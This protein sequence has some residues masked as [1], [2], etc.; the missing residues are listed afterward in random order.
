MK[1]NYQTYYQILF[2][3]ATL[4]VASSAF[5]QKSNRRYSEADIL[6]EAAFMEADALFLRG[7]YTESI[8]KF[9]AFLL[10][11]HDVA[12]AH[13]LLGRAYDAQNEHQKSMLAI[14]KAID[15]DPTNKWF[16]VTQA[17][18]Y[19]KNGQA[20]KAADVMLQLIKVEPKSD[21]AYKK[22]AFYYLLAQMPDKAIDILNQG[23]K[24]VGCDIEFCQ[25]K[26][27]IYLAKGDSKSAINELQKIL[28]HFPKST[29][30]RAQLAD[31]YQSIGKPN[32]A[33]KQYRK[34]LDYDPF[35]A[36]ALVG[37][38]KRNIKVNSSDIDELLALMAAPNTSI[39][40]KITEIVPIITKAS[41]N[42]SQTQ[43]NQWTQLVETLQKQHPNNPKAA[44]VAG[45]MY[46]AIGKYDLALA[47][48]QK[49][50][51]K[52]KSVYS[53]WQQ[54]LDL[55]FLQKQYAEVIKTANTALDY[56]PNKSR[57]ML[58]SAEAKFRSNKP[59]EA[60][61]DYKQASFISGRNH[62]QKRFIFGRLA[63]IYLANNDLRNADKYLSKAQKL[64]DQRDPYIK[65]VAKE[66][67]AKKP[68]LYDGKWIQ[69]Y[70]FGVFLI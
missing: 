68:I 31:I 1:N 2:V 29:K 59:K 8:D 7:K 35:N 37:L 57:I 51:K 49:A 70:P 55:L 61:A 60:I 15:L 27:V 30:I 40:I 42:A 67:Q 20:D 23:E 18:M 25:R 6:A 26:H 22:A 14:Q 39:D 36:I 11:H 38:Q 64:D 58:Y 44:S 16:I 48:F 3:A 52:E 9:K 12:I 28:K 34:I 45:D 69:L 24:I 19:E 32:E 10:E 53:L 50:L 66:V 13:F 21:F 63:E 33:E 17:S 47:A 54:T 5:A 46:N 4:L 56:F 43:K 62:H 65:H 41:P